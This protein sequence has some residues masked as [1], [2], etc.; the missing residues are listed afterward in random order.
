MK[1]V[2]K[3]KYDVDDRHQRGRKRHREVVIYTYHD[4]QAVE[5]LALE[6]TPTWLQHVVE[7]T[8]RCNELLLCCRERCVDFMLSMT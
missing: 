4:D 6:S 8:L 1:G 7:V 5:V 3:D 2:R